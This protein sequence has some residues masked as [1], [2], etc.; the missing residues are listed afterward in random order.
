MPSSRRRMAAPFAAFRSSTSAL[1]AAA[2]SITRC[3][4]SWRNSSGSVQPPL[5]PPGLGYLRLSTNLSAKASSAERSTCSSSGSPATSYASS[6][7]RYRIITVQTSHWTLLLRGPDSSCRWRRS[8]GGVAVT[9]TAAR[10]APQPSSY[11]AGILVSP[12]I[13]P[14]YTYLRRVRSRSPS[15]RRAVRAQPSRGRVS[16]APDAGEGWGGLSAGHVVRRSV[17]TRPLCSI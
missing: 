17:V 8:Q 11:H 10:Q 15:A 7:P 6:P 16:M 3:S 9:L 4:S 14:E 12:R 1:T 5:G 13:S 2:W